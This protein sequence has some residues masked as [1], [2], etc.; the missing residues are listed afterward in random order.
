MHAVFVQT[1]QLSGNRVVAYA[2]TANGDLVRRSS[3]ATGGKGG[4]AS[5]GTES[6]HLASQGSLVYEDGLL[7]AVNA[8]SDSV[9]LFAVRGTHLTLEDVVSSGGAFPNSIAVRNGLA[10][11]LNAGGDANVTGFRVGGEK[12]HRLQGSTRSLGITNTDPPN[13]LTAPGQVGFTPGGGQ[14]IVTTKASASTIDVFNVLSNGRLSDEAVANPAA[15][16]VPFAFTFAP[17]GRLVSGEA[18]V[19]AL[20]TYI[21]DSA[22]TLSDPKSLSDNQAALCWV[23]PA[24]GF[25]Y[26]SNT[27][28]DTVSAYRVADDGEPSLVGP[29]GVVAQTNPGPIDSTASG[30]F[31]YVETGTSA[32]VDE[33]NVA[34]DG[35]LS[36]IGTVTG[37]SVGIEG[38]AST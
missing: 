9:S 4:L 12:L 37:L 8:G 18:G 38:I 27:G 17:S 3:Y 22:G 31:L 29:T 23:T 13:F 26:V 30:G 11:V 15:T 35:T 14:L 21:V 25:Y 5:P 7:F 2:Q 19:S 1:N 16:P 24:G 28:S 34:A 10:Y 33:F 20:T 32:T 6:D 36:Q